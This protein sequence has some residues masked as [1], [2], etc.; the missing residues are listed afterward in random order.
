MNS[1][2]PSPSRVDLTELGASGR[3]L[4]DVAILLNRVVGDDAWLLVGGWMVHC[5]LALLGRRLGRV[6]DDVDVVVDVLS[7]PRSV[8]KIHEVLAEVGYR[9]SPSPMGVLHHRF[10]SPSGSVDLLFPDHLGRSRAR[11]AGP[12]LDGSRRLFAV[13]Y[14]LD[15]AVGEKVARLQLPRLSGAVALKVRAWVSRRQPRDLSDVCELVLGVDDPQDLISVLNHFELRCLASALR[16]VVRS[17]AVHL[18]HTEAEVGRFRGLL[19]LV[20][21]AR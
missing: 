2:S 1:E 5:H 15:V 16:E 13:R 10:S 8:P 11:S 17:T 14:P 6:T 19:A 12:Q 7:T 4:F 18:A 20:E 21:Q 9:R 3:H